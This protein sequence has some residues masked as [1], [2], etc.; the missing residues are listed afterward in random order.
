MF[1]DFWML[2][3]RLCSGHCWKAFLL[4]I[5]G[6]FVLQDFPFD[7]DSG[8][9]VPVSLVG[10]FSSMQMLRFLHQY[11]DAVRLVLAIGI[12]SIMP[13]SWWRRCHVK[14]HNEKL[15]PAKPRSAIREIGGAI[16]AITLV[17]SAVLYR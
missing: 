1:R 7:V 2:R 8:D 15:P 17:M 16:I 13:L 10:T 6:I 12:V 14:M 3:F 9:S 5:R 11:A 4:C